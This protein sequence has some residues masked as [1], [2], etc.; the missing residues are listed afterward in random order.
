MAERDKAARTGK[1]MFKRNFNDELI[2]SLENSDLYKKMLGDIKSGIVFPGIRS[3]RI[4]FYHKGGKLFTF[5]KDGFKTHIKYA[6]VY[7]S[8]ED[9]VSESKIL[10]LERINSFVDGYG[11]IKENCSLYAGIES[12]GVASIYSGYSYTASMSEVVVLDIE[13]SLESLDSDRN[14]DRIDILLFD[15]RRKQLVFC[16]AKH[17]SNKEIWSQKGSVPDVV[18]QV[19]RYVKQLGAKC[20]V[21]LKEYGNYVNAVNKLFSLNLPRPESIEQDVVL[22]VFGFDKDQLS[23][24]FTELFK[25]NMPKDIRYYAIGNVASLKIENVFKKCG[26]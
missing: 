26:L 10:R 20:D 15:R 16:E 24:R 9:Y 12:S 8:N 25:T 18:G 11:R 22:M 17:Y 5:D 19:Q 4:D 14:Q 7:K 23:G 13:V 6:S 3:E 2:K 1:G 21:I